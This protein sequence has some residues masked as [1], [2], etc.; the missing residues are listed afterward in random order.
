MINDEG[1]KTSNR[2]DACAQETEAVG[3][4]EVEAIV[5]VGDW[6][7][8]YRHRDEI[9]LCGILSVNFLIRKD[10]CC[11]A[12]CGKDSLRKSTITEQAQCIILKELFQSNLHGL[13]AGP[14]NIH[15]VPVRI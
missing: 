10:A 12:S 8:F 1:V 4:E 15:D 3:E 6:P 13:G 7:G 14:I 9:R 2:T 5:A 11:E